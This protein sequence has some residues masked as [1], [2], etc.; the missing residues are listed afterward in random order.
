[1]PFLPDEA[2]PDWE[3]LVTAI[4]GYSSHQETV[5]RVFPFCTFVVLFVQANVIYN[6][7]LCRIWPRFNVKIEQFTALFFSEI[8]DGFPDDAFCF[9]A[10]DN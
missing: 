5:H 8:I 1:M 7:N 3:L 6:L 9:E 2:T 10:L 4:K